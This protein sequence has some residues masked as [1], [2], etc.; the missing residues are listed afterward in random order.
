MNYL[1]Y[2]VWFC[3]QPEYYKFA[4]I[5]YQSTIVDS[6][7][8]GLTQLEPINGLINN[9]YS[10]EITENV[11]ANANNSI[12]IQIINGLVFAYINK[13]DIKVGMTKHI[14]IYDKYYIKN[15]YFVFAEANNYTKTIIN[16]NTNLTA[17]NIISLI[18]SGI[19]V[20]KIQE[21]NY[22]SYL[23]NMMLN[24][25]NVKATSILYK[26]DLKEKDNIECIII[27]KDKGNKLSNLGKFNLSQLSSDNTSLLIVSHST[28][29][30]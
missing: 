3:S 23:N 16:S 13:A 24:Y 12:S 22:L 17:L 28:K 25:L 20:T 14:N 1:E 15:K 9:T 11:N 7:T 8:L 29:F 6:S 19:N 27:N 30:N 21:T 5:D 26:F 18:K 4:L 10:L 2:K